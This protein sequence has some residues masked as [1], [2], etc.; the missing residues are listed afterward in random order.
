MNTKII[1]IVPGEPNST[2][3]EILFKYFSS[4]NFNKS[5]KKIIIVGSKKLLEN[6]MKLLKYKIH[7][8]EINDILWMLKKL[9]RRDVRRI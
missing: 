2:F 5:K 1:L 6:Q 8:N 9:V 7:F 4:K 3:S